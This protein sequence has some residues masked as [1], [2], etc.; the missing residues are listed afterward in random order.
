MNMLIKDT[1]SGLECGARV[2]RWTFN[3]LSAVA[4]QLSLMIHHKS[5][6]SCT[7]KLS[8]HPKAHSKSESLQAKV[9]RQL[10]EGK[11]P[12]GLMRLRC[13]CTIT[14]TLAHQRTHRR[15]CI[16]RKKKNERT[17]RKPREWENGCCDVW[18]RRR[19]SSDSR[20]SR[21]YETQIS[22]RRIIQ[23]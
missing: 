1:K 8:A 12:S 17:W 14:R 5:P 11:L 10:A 22:F 13:H 18:T 21:S 6:A 9:S 15:G 3:V 19:P 16:W 23:S 20:S 7:S 4:S 2:E